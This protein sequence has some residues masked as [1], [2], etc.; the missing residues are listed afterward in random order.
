MTQYV[1]FKVQSFKIETECIVSYEY[2][3]KTILTLKFK[4]QIYN[5][6]GLWS[7]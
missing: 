5:S 6:Y 1:K 3:V 4:I 7:E 2:N